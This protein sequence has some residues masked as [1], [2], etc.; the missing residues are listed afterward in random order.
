MKILMTPFSHYLGHN[1]RLLEIAKELKEKGHKIIFACEFDKGNLIKKEG[2]EV[3]PIK[4]YDY[5]KFQKDFLPKFKISEEEI[6]EMVKSETKILKEISPDLVISDFHLS[7]GISTEITK[8]PH[9]SILNTYSSK[10]Y[11]TFLSFPP[12]FPP[13]KYLGKKIDFFS[14]LIPLT[15]KVILKIL[16]E[17]FNRIRKKYKLT[18]KKNYLEQ[19]EGNYTFLCDIPSLFKIKKI[20]KNYFIIGPLYYLKKKKFPKSIK[21]DKN[22]KTIYLSIGSEKNS[23]LLKQIISNINPK[24]YQIITSS[25]V[26]KKEGTKIHPLNFFPGISLIEKADIV[27]CHG[28]NGT[29]YQALSLKK[30]VIAIP[31]NIDHNFNADAIE[32][33]KIGRKVSP[34]EIN[35]IDKIIEELLNF[36]EYRENLEKVS[37]EM[38]EYKLKKL[39]FLIEKL[40]NGKR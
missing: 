30:P 38:K 6:L 29:L 34:E 10:A 19:L 16:N 32:K 5:E 15:R 25:P 20:P 13:R 1:L 9:I 31:S 12:I 40:A 21:L 17:P 7:T 22:K 39:V 14:F 26:P 18:L 2:F 33:N 36:K 27:I 23:K 24:K 3:I 8:I 11:T 37:N 28:G 35:K 4:E